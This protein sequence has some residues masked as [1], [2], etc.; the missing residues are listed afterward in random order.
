MKRWWDILN[1]GRRTPSS[2]RERK[3]EGLGGAML[4]PLCSSADC[5]THNVSHAHFCGAEQCGGEM[6][7]GRKGRVAEIRQGAGRSRSPGGGGSNF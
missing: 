7:V 4:C 3:G 1:G 5:P 2:E 6:S